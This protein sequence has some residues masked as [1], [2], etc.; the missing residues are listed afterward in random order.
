MGIALLT[1]S[2]GQKCQKLLAAI[3]R[4]II[5]FYAR[6][7]VKT[8]PW[9]DCNSIVTSVIAL[10][11]SPYHTLILWHVPFLSI[12]HYPFTKNHAASQLWLNL[13]YFIT[14]I[15]VHNACVCGL[16]NT[17]FSCNCGFLFT[18]SKIFQLSVCI[19]LLC[20]LCCFLNDF[21]ALFCCK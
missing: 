2:S 14:T 16:H 4:F 9:D 5:F 21:A 17:D 18:Q 15:L 7:P 1:P 11:L 8:F 10:K 13:Y 3:W 6:F 20:K 19:R 12:S